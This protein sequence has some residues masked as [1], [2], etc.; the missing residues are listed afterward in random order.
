MWSKGPGSESAD[1]LRRMAWEIVMA[2]G[3]QTS[4][5]T[6]RRGTNVWPDTGGGWM[7]GRGDDTM[8]M[9]QGYGHMVDFFTSFKWWE[10]E[11][12]DELVSRGNY[13]LAKRGETYAIYL[14]NSGNVTVRLEPGLYQA[15]WWEAATGKQ[16]PLPTVD[17]VA[18]SWTSPQ[19]PGS[20]DWALLVRRQPLH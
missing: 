20:G 15:T 11:P 9:F 18:S 19:A 8:T 6:A 2:G 10:T 14:P 1:M 7:N 3:Y 12:H 13:C 4:G 16:T 5:E 17:A